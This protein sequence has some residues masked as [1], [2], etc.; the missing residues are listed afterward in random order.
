[1]GERYAPISDYGFIGDCHSAA[2]VSRD[3][4]ID[5]C[6]LPRID[7]ASTFGRILDTDK[8]GF[9]QIAPTGPY[10]ARRRYV[11]DTLVL[12]TTFVSGESEARLLD[13]FVMGEGGRERPRREILRV[14][15]GVRGEMDVAIRI[16]PRF[17]YGLTIPEITSPTTCHVCIG[18]SHGIVV[19]GDPDLRVDGRHALAGEATIHEGERCRLS[20][21]F[22]EP[23]V[24]D[25]EDP[26][27]CV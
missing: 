11:D 22:R 24:L 23:H 3:G 2:L 15:E 18:G 13:C 20:I 10:D 6:C 8:G 25:A 17:D 27:S 12:E 26:S 19:G 14:L 5:W 16:E 9:T 1:M 4:S 21:R 7:S